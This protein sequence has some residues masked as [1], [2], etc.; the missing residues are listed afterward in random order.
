MNFDTAAVIGSNTDI[1]ATAL[2]ST[3]LLL[4]V[5]DCSVMTALSEKSILRLISRGKIR[6][7]SSIRHKRIPVS[8]LTR[9]IRDNLK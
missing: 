7:L 3:K 5:R 1:P 9:F 6:A 4:T 2:S 8:E